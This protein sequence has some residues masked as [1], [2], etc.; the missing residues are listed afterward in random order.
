ME[1][2]NVV[3][4]GKEYAVLGYKRIKAVVNWEKKKIEL[5]AYS[6][7]GSDYNLNIS[8]SFKT[9]KKYYNK[10]LNYLAVVKACY[11]KIDG[12]DY[13][14]YNKIEYYKSKDFKTLLKLIEEGIISIAFKISVYK[15]QDRLGKIHDRGTDFSIMYKDITLLFD[16]IET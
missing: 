1:R 2:L 12:N 13:F 9:L 15:D 10:K 5:K 7:Y 14:Y 4:S 6:T 11:K 3:F 8:W 16:Y